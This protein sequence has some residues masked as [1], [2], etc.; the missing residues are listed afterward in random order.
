MIMS[1]ISKTVVVVLIL[2]AG[3]TASA[4]A[5][6]AEDGV[7]AYKLGDYL[8]AMRFL[9]PLA[10][11]GNA[12]AQFLLGEIYG[13]GAGVEQDYT[14]ALTWY[15][16]AAE[17]GHAGAQWSLGVMYQ[18]GRDVPRAYAAAASWY[19]KAA[20]QGHVFAQYDLATMYAKGQGVLQDYVSSYMWYSLAAGKGLTD[21]ARERDMVAAQMTPAQIAEAQRLASEWQPHK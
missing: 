8:T 17:Q 9:R 6:P 4:S 3:I 7:A 10:H 11:Q 19:R 2:A 12:D 20:D 1:H 14:T 21:A 15:R 16:K 5:G 18:E 13:R